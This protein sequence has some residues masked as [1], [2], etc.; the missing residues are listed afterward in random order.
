MNFDGF[1]LIFCVSIFSVS[2]NM[3]MILYSIAVNFWF[4]ILLT[5][6]HSINV[7]KEKGGGVD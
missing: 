6:Q 3:S 4:W 5:A 7:S 1:Y 2:M